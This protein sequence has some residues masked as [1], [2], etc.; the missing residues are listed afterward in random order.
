MKNAER[1]LQRASQSVRERPGREGSPPCPVSE[2]L[3]DF[4]DIPHPAHSVDQL[5]LERI[6]DLDPQPAHVDVDHI[7]LALE[8]DVPDPLGYPG[9]GKDLAAALRQKGEE[10]EFLRR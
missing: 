8:I 6:V 4:Q 10:C 9:A 7:C 2:E 3:A 1:A 5:C